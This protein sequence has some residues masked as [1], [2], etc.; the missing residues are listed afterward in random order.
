MNFFQLKKIIKNVQLHCIY[1]TKKLVRVLTSFK[2]LLNC[3]KKPENYE[4]SQRFF[5]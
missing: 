1:N 2:Y 4:K 3:F 5:K